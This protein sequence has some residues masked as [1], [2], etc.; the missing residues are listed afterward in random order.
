MSQLTAMQRICGLLDRG[1]IA[2]AQFQTLFARRVAQDLGCTRAGV[3]LRVET[4]D[5]PVLRCA[6]MVGASGESI[7]VPDIPAAGAPDYFAALLRDGCVVAPDALRDPLTAP[8]VPPYLEPLDVQSTL[9]VAFSINGV[10]YGTFSCEQ[11]GDT[12]A[13]SPFQLNLLRQFASRV[14]LTLVNAMQARLD[15]APGVLWEPSAP[16]RLAS[17]PM[18]LD[19]DPR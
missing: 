11:V 1:E 8:F 7:G 6:G 2:L 13:W 15:T 16:D 9:D 3:R 4:A 12:M 17:L 18:A 5:G 10:L 14:S 19:I